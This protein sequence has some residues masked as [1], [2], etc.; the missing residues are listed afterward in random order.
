MP[1]STVEDIDA[2]MERAFSAMETDE[3]KLGKMT[4]RELQKYVEECFASGKTVYID[5][6][7]F[8]RKAMGILQTIGNLRLVGETGTGKSTLVSHL[9]ETMG[10]AKYEYS[11]NT[12][13]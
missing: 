2:E 13:P 5:R 9:T 1:K 10:W 3:S 12:A 6:K 4:Q 11:L 8:K 7:G